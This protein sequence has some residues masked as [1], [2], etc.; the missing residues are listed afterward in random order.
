MRGESGKPFHD[1]YGINL[2]TAAR[3]IKKVNP[4]TCFSHRKLLMLTIFL[5]KKTKSKNINIEVLKILII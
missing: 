1:K 4:L 3:C 2:E 5:T